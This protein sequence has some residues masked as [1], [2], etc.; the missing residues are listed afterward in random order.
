MVFEKIAVRIL[1]SYSTLEMTVPAG[2]Y[3]AHGRYVQITVMMIAFY[4]VNI[5]FFF[6]QIGLYTGQK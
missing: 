1:F 5:S 2:L 3:S 4:T 6:A